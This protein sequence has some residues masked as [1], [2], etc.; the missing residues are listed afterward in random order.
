MTTP[1][2]PD[3]DQSQPGG[4]HLPPSSFPPPQQPVRQRA[5]RWLIAVGTALAVL[6]VAVVLVGALGSSTPEVGDCL[7][8]TGTDRLQTVD[9][10]DAT[11]DYRIVGIESGTTTFAD[12]EADA[13]TCSAFPGFEQSFWVGANGDETG[14]GT[15]YC[16][17]A[18]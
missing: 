6:V 5:P 2:R 11:T 17:A 18:P 12:Y 15:V 9:C 8:S 1:A 4:T 10:D 7:E 3:P 16:V 14:Q 13:T